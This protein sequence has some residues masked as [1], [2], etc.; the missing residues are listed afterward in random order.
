MLEETDSQLYRLFKDNLPHKEYNKKAFRYLDNL[1]WGQRKLLLSLLEFIV[2]YYD[3]YDKTQKKYMLYL[4]SA[5]GDNIN[6][7]SNLF[8]DITFILYDMVEHNIEPSDNIII[9]QKYFTNQEAEKYKDMNLFM[10]SDIRSL[11]IGRYRQIGNKSGENNVIYTDMMYQADWYKIIRPIK[12]MLKFRVVWTES[13][14]LY[15]DGDIF[16]QPWNKN[17]SV[18][19]RLVPFGDPSYNHINTLSREKINNSKVVYNKLY[20]SISDSSSDSSNKLYYV[21]KSDFNPL[22]KKWDNKKIEEILFYHNTIHRR[23]KI[24]VNN[25]KSDKQFIYC[26]NCKCSRNYYDD[27]VENYILYN[28]LIKF[29]PNLSSDDTKIKTNICNIKA[30]IT[31]KLRKYRSRNKDKIKDKYLIGL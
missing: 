18:E 21:D 23:K 29:R 1:H 15:F 24:N 3:Y 16:I 20:D 25:I 6:F 26:I 9:N 30:D 27:L 22:L 2:N 12:A 10:Y 14:T 13:I 17:D 31:A 28:F 7:V 4:G 11:D 8:P 19:L 5:P